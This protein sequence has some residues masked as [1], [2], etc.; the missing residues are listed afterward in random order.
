MLK[1]KVITIIVDDAAA[2]C[3]CVQT[4]QLSAQNSLVVVKTKIELDSHADT[5]VVGDDCL[6]VHEQNRPLNTF[7]Y[8]PKGNQIVLA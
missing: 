4:V 8:D 5:C 7:E 2:I 1:G 3:T 6:V